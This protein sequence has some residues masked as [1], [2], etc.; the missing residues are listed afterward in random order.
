MNSWGVNGVAV[1]VV[2]KDSLIYSQGFGYGDSQRK[3]LIKPETVFSIASIAKPIIALTTIILESDGKID[4]ELPIKKHLNG[5]EF[6]DKII[7]NNLTFKDLMLHRSGFSR[8]EE[9]WLF[10]TEPRDSLVSKWSKLTPDK[11]FRSVYQYSEMSFHTLCYVIEQVV[12]TSWED[13]VQSTLFQPLGFQ[14]TSFGPLGLS[15]SASYSNPFIKIKDTISQVQIREIG[16]AGSLNSSIIDLSKLVQLFLNNGSFK[17]NRI[18][19]KESVENVIEPRIVVPDYKNRKGFNAQYGYGWLIDNHRNHRV[20]EHD[21]HT[22]GFSCWVSIL[23]DS[24][25]GIIVL[26]NND[27]SPL[28]TIIKKNIIDRLLGLDQIDYNAEYLEKQ[29]K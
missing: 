24:E 9:I 25:L 7:Q 17:N 16:V 27:Y 14:H 18:L 26:T 12:N 19:S 29:Q 6:S 20:I 22:E 5:V 15:N 2:G 10:S 4:S 13:Y 21:G 8:H 3:N 1:A 11:P 23:P 28:N